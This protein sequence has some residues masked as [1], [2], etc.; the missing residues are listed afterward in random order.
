MGSAETPKFR[1]GDVLATVFTGTLTERHGDTVEWIPTPGRLL[2][3]LAVNDLAVEHCSD[4]EL[5]SAYRLR[6]AIHLA[7]TA[8]AT[9]EPLPASALRTIN[10]AARGGR[11]CPQLSPH[12][13][14]RWRLGDS[15]AGC[16]DD[17][18]SVVAADALVLLAPANRDRLALCAS[19]TCQEMFVD[20]SQS[21][22]RRWCDM[23]I[24]GNRSKKARHRAATRPPRSGA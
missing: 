8:A 24:C 21:H 11:A 16:V 14:L 4:A 12:E 6:E 13:Q 10:E 3:W 2:D 19:P 9:G 5:A 20:N 15:G 7:G 17:A 1:T 18:L 23:N 22:T